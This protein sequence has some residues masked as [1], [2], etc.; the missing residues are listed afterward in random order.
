MTNQPNQKEKFSLLVWMTVPVLFLSLLFARTVYP[1]LVILTVALSILLVANLV[2]LFIQ[3]QKALKTR[4]AAMGLNSIVTVILV[5]GIV[6]VLNFL[7]NRY[8]KKWDLTK[9]QLH[10]LSDQTRKIVQ[11]LQKPVKGTFFASSMGREQ[12]RIL[13]EDFKHLSTKFQLEYVDS[14]RELSRAKQAGLK[15]DIPTLILNYEGKETKIE[16]PTEEKLTNA[17]IKITKEKTQTF[18]VI[19]GHGE[20]NFSSS[21]ADGYQSVK[22]SLEG[23]SYETKEISLLPEGKIPESC[24]ALA[25]IGPTR[26]FFDAEV[27]IL[28]DYFNN[29]GRGLIALDLN[30]E[31][32]AEFTPEL[33]K[34]LEDWHIRPA[35]TLVMDP[36]SAYFQLGASVAMLA[37]FSK[38]SPITK[39]Q[40]NCAFPITSPLEIIP[41]APAGMNVQWIAKTTPASVGITDLSKIKGEVEFNPAKDKQGPFTVAVSVE[42]KQKDSKAARN[43]RLVAFG[44]SQFATNQYGRIAG[45]FDLFLNAVSWTME[46]EN[47]ISIR[48]KEDGPGRIELSKKTAETVGFLTAL[49]IPGLFALSGLGVWMRRRKL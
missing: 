34:L 10:T 24:N 14:L 28:R 1:E 35:K 6:G 46:E 47:L 2:I 25:V 15:R 43:T 27:K 40:I 31:K 11:A 5:I 42:G 13:M 22:K 20:K 29:G 26:G 39:D 4:T 38:E 37:T 18:C 44:S 3:N 33:G 32:N 19:T 30:L 48:K 45:N 8:T 16:E 7:G 21:E 41:G 23:Q 9:G 12:Y 49:V 17:L 36:V